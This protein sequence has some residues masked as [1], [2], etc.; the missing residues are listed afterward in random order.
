MGFFDAPE[1]PIRIQV[2]HIENRGSRV[3]ISYRATYADKRKKTFRSNVQLLNSYMGSQ[4]M[5]TITEVEY[6]A[7]VYVGFLKSD[8]R[9]I[10]LVKLK[11]GTMEL[12]Q[13]SEKSAWCNE[14]LAKALDSEEDWED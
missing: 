4:F 3:Y 1:R 6:I 12:L 2:L 7:T 14:L 13:A 5:P 11:D 8:G 10:F 9:M